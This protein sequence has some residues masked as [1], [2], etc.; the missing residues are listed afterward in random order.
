MAKE[1]DMETNTYEVHFNEFRSDKE[2]QESDEIEMKKYVE[3]NPKAPVVIDWLN[4]KKTY[5]EYKCHPP[6]D[7]SICLS[8]QMIP[9]YDSDEQEY[10]KYICEFEGWLSG[11]YPIFEDDPAIIK[12]KKNGFV[13]QYCNKIRE[14]IETHIDPFAIDDLVAFIDELKKEIMKMYE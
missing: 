13:I 4:G 2:K 5:R 11:R 9:F 12:W 7:S 6:L 14:W 3:N 1:K 10:S 8:G